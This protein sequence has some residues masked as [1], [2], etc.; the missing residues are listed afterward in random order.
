MKSY[1][2]QRVLSTEA[3]NIL[4]DLQNSSYP[5]KAK[6]NNCFTIHSK[7]F[8]TLKGESELFV[9]VLIKNNTTSSPGFLGERCNN[10]QQAALL[11]SSIQYIKIISK[12]GQQL[13]MVNRPFY[14][15]V[16]SYLAM[17][18]SEAGVDL[19]L[20]QTSLFF[21]CKCKLVSIRTT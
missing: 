17:N 13:V 16:L 12:F 20:I 14:S 6:F 8:Q 10:L 5:S 1:A 2:D 4:R 7:Y 11:M 3:D 9:F 19:A 15:C 21:S 18:A